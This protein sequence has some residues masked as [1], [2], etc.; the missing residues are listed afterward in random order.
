MFTNP[1]N[2]AYILP[3]SEEMNKKE[4]G[5]NSLSVCSSIPQLICEYQDI[6]TYQPTNLPSPVEAER[7]LLCLR[8]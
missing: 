3:S 8:P 6:P 5:E 1:T 7:R 4:F 2:E